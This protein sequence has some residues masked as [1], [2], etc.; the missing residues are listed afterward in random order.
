MNACLVITHLIMIG[1]DIGAFVNWS[2]KRI[3]D[4]CLGPIWFGVG[5]NNQILGSSLMV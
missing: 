5:G 4:S 2:C 3:L 1:Q